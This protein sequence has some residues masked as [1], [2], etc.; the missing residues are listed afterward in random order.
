MKFYEFE[1]DFDYYALIGAENI[2][3]AKEL[4]NECICESEEGDPEE[5][6][7]QQAKEKLYDSCES[8]EQKREELLAF[9]INMLNEKSFLVLIDGCLL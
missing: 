5:L 4:Y 6:T 9:S 8:N 2:D 7:L 3:D 1:K